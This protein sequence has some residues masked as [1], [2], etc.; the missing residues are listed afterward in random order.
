MPGVLKL[1]PYLRKQ[2]HQGKKAWSM[3]SGLIWPAQWVRGCV[4][5]HNPPHPPTEAC[6][7]PKTCCTKAKKNSSRLVVLCWILA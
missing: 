1:L 3:D 6:P 7:Q 2:R 4:R 5:T